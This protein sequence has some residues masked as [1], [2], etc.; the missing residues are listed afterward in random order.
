MLG[1]FIIGFIFKQSTLIYSFSGC[2]PFFNQYNPIFPPIRSNF[3]PCDNMKPQFIPNLPPCINCNSYQQ[4]YQGIYSQPLISPPIPPSKPIPIPVIT[5]E[6]NQQNPIHIPI[7]KTIYSNTYPT[8]LP[9]T[10][11]FSSNCKECFEKLSILKY[12]QRTTLPE[13]DSINEKNNMLTKIPKVS[14]KYETSL[15]QGLIEQDAYDGTILSNTDND[16]K[17]IVENVECTVPPNITFYNPPPATSS[18]PTSECCVGCD[19]EEECQYHSTY[20]S[21]IMSDKKSKKIRRLFGSPLV[22]TDV[23]CT[24]KQLKNILSHY[25]GS[26]AKSSVKII[27]KL[28]DDTLLEAHN[29]ICSEG[30]FYYIARSSSFC[31]LSIGNVHCYIFRVIP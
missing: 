3:L 31:Q 30:T 7:Y 10:N 18:Y 1:Y 6:Q 13:G 27:Q 14:T 17:K 26:D 12:L 21:N 11:I 24:N 19:D 22:N 23:K 20:P 15:K 16:D 8:Q 4:S 28:A 29:V 2:E 25:I 9:S 5:E